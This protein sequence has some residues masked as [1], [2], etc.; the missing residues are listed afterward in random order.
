MNPVCIGCG[1]TEQKACWSALEERPCSWL[2]HDKVA[3][4]GVCSACKQHLGRWDAGDRDRVTREKM[5]SALEGVGLILKDVQRLHG[6]N[7]P[8]SV[9]RVPRVAVD[10]DQ[11]RELA[12]LAQARLQD[13][14]HLHDV[15]RGLAPFDDSGL[16]S[17]KRED[18]ADAA[19]ER[20][21]ILIAAAT[22]AKAE[23]DNCT[24][25]DCEATREAKGFSSCAGGHLARRVVK[26][27]ENLAV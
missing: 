6:L 27:I 10:V 21:R 18:S 17:V 13:H 23:L 2:R 15:F 8:D 11:L 3:R 20:R 26:V 16:V 4:V 25:P 5:A 19:E 14:L 1:C 24:H 7:V 9:V 22:A 12:R